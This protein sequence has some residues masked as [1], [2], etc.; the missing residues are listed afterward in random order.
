M[1][2]FVVGLFIVMGAVGSQDV[3]IEAGTEAP[4]LIE[5]VLWSILG[6]MLMAFGAVKMNLMEESA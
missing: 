5:T 6:L 3:A 4:A 2:R 1:I